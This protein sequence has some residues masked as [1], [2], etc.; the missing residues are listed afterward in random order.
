MSKAIALNE[1]K[2][3]ETVLVRVPTG[4]ET[5]TGK[6]ED[7]GM[8]SGSYPQPYAHIAPLGYHLAHLIT[9]PYTVERI[10]A[11]GY[12]PDPPAAPRPVVQ[13]APPIDESPR[14]AAS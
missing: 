9:A 6:V 1:L 4:S 13:L 12:D 8:S 14:R 3:G 10:T 2:K 11:P 7:A 5:W